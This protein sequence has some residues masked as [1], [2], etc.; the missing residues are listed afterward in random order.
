MKI[1]DL[2]KAGVSI[3]DDEYLVFRCNSC[4]KVWLVKKPEDDKVSP[5]DWHCSFNYCND[6]GAKKYHEREMD[7]LRQ[8]A[9]EAEGNGFEPF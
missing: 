5:R 2:H 7:M 6:P 8:M 4:N 9:K 3:V 1:K